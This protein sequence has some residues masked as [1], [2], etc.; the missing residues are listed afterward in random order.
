MRNTQTFRCEFF[1]SA[2]RPKRFSV[3]HNFL[4]TLPKLLWSRTLVHTHIAS[5]AVRL[6][7]YPLSCGGNWILSTRRIFKDISQFCSHFFFAASM[8]ERFTWWKGFEPDFPLSL[9]PMNQSTS[10]KSVLQAELVSARLR[11]Y[12]SP[13]ENRNCCLCMVF[14]LSVSSLTSTKT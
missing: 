6:T 9:T 7:Q 4:S 3:L 5:I 11:T 14:T 8:F 10:R 1:F 2:Q 13:D 12:Q